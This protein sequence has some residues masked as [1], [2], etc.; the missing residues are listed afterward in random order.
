MEASR[1]RCA[2]CRSVPAAAA[3]LALA[4]GC[5]PTQPPPNAATVPVTPRPGVAAPAAQGETQLFVRAVPAGS[6]RQEYPGA[7][8][9]AE[10]AY[11]T[12][13]FTAPARLLIPDFGTAAPPVS[14]TCRA[15]S[16]TGT[17]TAAPEAAWS[18]GLGGWPAVG[19]SVGTGTAGGVGVGVGW[20]GGGAGTTSGVPV[21][22][23]NELRV[24]LS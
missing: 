1:S 16:A 3:L 23:Y 10:T 7:S 6:T 11:F 2:A 9:R 13:D 8:C 18:G 15:G 24:P 19:V 4:A 14:V 17:A 5:S 21:T 22:R 12:A 20:W